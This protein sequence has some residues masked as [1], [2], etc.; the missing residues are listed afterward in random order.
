MPKSSKEGKD[1]I[2][3][4]LLD[5]ND[6]V[7]RVID[8]GPGRGTYHKYYAR[9]ARI[10][11]H[12][13]WIGIEVWKPYLEEFGLK[14]IYDE[15]YVEDVRFFDFSKIGDVDLV[16]AGDI[17]EHMTKE[18]SVQVVLEILKYS[19]KLIISIP[20]IYHPQGAY[21]GN[22]F[23]IHVKDDWSHEEV[24]DTFPHIKKHHKGEA[25]GVYLLEK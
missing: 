10:L 4:W 19:K 14:D 18:E 23:E 3:N 1:I 13:H 24:L 25:I 21:G 20:I 2:R 17:L 12:A 8:L 15:V 7:S 9:K 6:T 11:T 5:F 16:F 22:P